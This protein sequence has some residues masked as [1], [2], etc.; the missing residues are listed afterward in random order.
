MRQNRRMKSLMEEFS[1]NRMDCV[2]YKKEEYPIWNKT[3][4]AGRRYWGVSSFWHL[5]LEPIPAEEDLSRLEWDGNEICLDAKSDKDTANMLKKAMGIAA[6]WK[7]ELETRY[8]ET[9][10][11]IIA[12]YDN[13]DMMIQEEDEL[14]TRSIT[15]RFWAHRGQNTVINLDCFEDW[16]QP[17]MIAYCNFPTRD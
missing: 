2:P 10:F 5:D 15:L 8:P 9:P 1:I 3:D 12:S 14:P 4:S 16:E 13:G 11:Y 6:F 17:A 7:Q